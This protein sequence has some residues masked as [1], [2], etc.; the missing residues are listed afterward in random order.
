MKTTIT[1][2]LGQDIEVAINHVNW[3]FAGYGHK[4]ITVELDYNGSI[5]TFGVKTSNMM[6]FDDASEIEDYNEKQMAMYN[7]ISYKLNDI[8]A[9][10]IYELENN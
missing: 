3:S 4:L 2:H 9:D 5:K 8:I 10:W 7:I 6:A 1:N